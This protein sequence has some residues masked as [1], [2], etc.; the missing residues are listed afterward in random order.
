[1]TFDDDKYVL[2]SMGA[3]HQN[4][5]FENQKVADLCPECYNTIED[6]INNKEERH[7]FSLPYSIEQAQKFLKEQGYIVYKPTKKGERGGKK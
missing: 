1:M 4:M 6:Y 5:G 3:G 7:T 2:M